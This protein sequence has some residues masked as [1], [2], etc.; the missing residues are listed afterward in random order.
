MLTNHH[1]TIPTPSL[2]QPQ[3]LFHQFSASPPPPS[4]QISDFPTRSSTGSLANS[5]SD[6]PRSGRHFEPWVIPFGAEVVEIS[7]FSSFGRPASLCGSAH[8]PNPLPEMTSQSLPTAYPFLLPPHRPIRVF[9]ISPA[10]FASEPHRPQ[11]HFEA[12]VNADT[13]TA[14]VSQLVHVSPRY[15]HFS[16]FP[17][18]FAISP[19]T[20]PIL[21]QSPSTPYPF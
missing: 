8:R 14:S 11:T 19:I 3:S 12:L 21:R 10:H 6:S 13:F 18:F 7:G 4:A 20:F 17:P 5:D 9:P 1:P 16:Q 2:I 15:S